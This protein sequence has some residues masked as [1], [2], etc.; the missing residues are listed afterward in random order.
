MICQG[1]DAAIIIVSAKLVIPKE[2]EKYITI[3]EMDYLGSGD[4]KKLLKSLFV[5]TAWMIFRKNCLKSFKR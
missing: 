2:L 1:V 3:L 4:I 5:I